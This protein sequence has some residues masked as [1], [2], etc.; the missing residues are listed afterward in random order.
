LSAGFPPYN[1]RVHFTDYNTRLAAYAVLVNEND[2]ILLTWFN[3]GA[4]ESEQGWSLPGGGVNFDEG[5]EDAV[6]RETYEE[7]GYVVEVGPLLAMSHF[8]APFSRRRAL[9]FRSQRLLFAATIVGGQLGT[10]EV[11]G[12][13]DFARWIPLADFPLPEHSVGIVDLA[14][15]C[16]ERRN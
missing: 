11:G 16:L 1:R 2:E 6:V 13:T 14:V 8:T 4:G 3:G 7:T 10:I 12:T 15:K 5:I 9:P